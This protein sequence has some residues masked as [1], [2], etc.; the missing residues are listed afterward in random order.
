[1]D[2]MD[3]TVCY[4]IKVVKLNYLLTSGHMRKYWFGPHYEGENHPPNYGIMLK[5]YEPNHKL[6]VNDHTV[7][8]Y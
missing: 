1:M 4:P 2:Y 5:Y 6:K 8:E 3:L 7:N